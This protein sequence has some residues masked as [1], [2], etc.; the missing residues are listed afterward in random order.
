MSKIKVGDTFQSTSCNTFTII[1]VKN[2]EN[3]TIKFNDTQGYEF[4]ASSQNIRNGRIKNPYFPRL[5]D[6]GYF[7]AGKYKARIGSSSVNSKSTNEYRSWINMLSR[8]YDPNYI[9][10]K[11]GQ[12]C[13][14]GVQVEDS[15]LNFQV[16]AEWYCKELVVVELKSPETKFVLD[17][18]L[19]SPNV[20]IYSPET[21]CLIPEQL[22]IVLVDKLSLNKTRKLS[23]I[24]KCK[25]GTYSIGVSL[26]KKFTTFSGY[27]TE[28]ECFDLYLSIKEK[29]L[30]NLIEKYKF[31]LNEK[32][33]LALIEYSSEKSRRISA[34][35]DY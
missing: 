11:A 32:V 12:M 20:K 35:Y 14:S 28:K 19:L 1:E 33:Y 5:F 9:G 31:L 8:C 23:T 10:T 17:K 29:E 27:K 13:Y 4:I 7:G 24:R 34:H 6:K 26:N 21:C 25:N 16:F 3:I 18:D 22:N 30:N 2:Q 15:W